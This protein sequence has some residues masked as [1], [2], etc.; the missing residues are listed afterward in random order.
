MNFIYDVLEENPRVQI[1]L[2][3]TKNTTSYKTP[4]FPNTTI[5]RFGKVSSNPLIRYISYIY[6]NLF[7]SFILLVSKAD[8]ITAFDSLS[9]FPLWLVKKAQP[10]SKVHIHF[11]EYISE[12]ERKASS[13]YMKFL[14][15]LEDQ[16]LVKFP[17][18]QTNEDRKRLFLLDKPFLNQDQV[19]VRPN[20]PP[21]SWWKNFGQYKTPSSDDKIRLVAVGACD[22]NTMYVR[23]VL[24]WVTANQE[25]LELTIISQEIPKETKNLILSYHCPVIYF[26]PPIDYDRLPEELV[27]YDYGLVLYKGVTNNHIFSVPNKVHEYL[28]CG[29]HVIVDHKLT[30]TV[31]LKNESILD[32]ELS[33]IN[34]C[35][36][37]KLKSR[38][39]K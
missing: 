28:A 34:E 22:N 5:Y 9:I 19:E 11:H 37:S 17:C 25:L 8:F 13:A 2:F 21:K 27:K 39:E 1:L 15:K 38:L 20:L 18:S 33:R 36:P 29:L 31:N 3:T 35:L 26:K 30:T 6:F 32:L 16:L 23:E 10:K 14:Y 7:S 24:D 12:P 4:S